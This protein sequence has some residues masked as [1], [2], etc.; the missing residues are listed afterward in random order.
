M[1]IL[2][3]IVDVVLNI[4]ILIVFLFLLVAIYNF[5]QLNIM[6]KQY[7]NYFGYSYFE[8]LSGSME[9]EIQVGDYVFVKIT[10]DV[11]EKDI[12]S[13]VDNEDVI[14]HR[15]VKIDEDEIIT[16][17]DNNN[18][19]DEPINKNQVIGKV[20][21]IGKSYGKFLNVVINPYVFIPFFAT[22]LFFSLAMSDGK[23]KGDVDETI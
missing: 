7:I 20:V 13:F 9:D 6:K 5:F 11:E 22:I 4:L 10:K 16:K 8:I 1:K 21:Y 23:K 19:T 14:T 18:A 3:K 2:N 15:I 12:I 17:G